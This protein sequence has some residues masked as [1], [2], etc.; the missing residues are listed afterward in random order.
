MK[1]ASTEKPVISIIIPTK[2]EERNI[3]LC[4]DSIKK[5]TFPQNEIEIIVVDNHSTDATKKIAREYTQNIFTKGPE[6]SAQRN[7]GAKKCHGK[8]YMYLDADMTLSPTVIQEVV[9]I[10]E[11]NK[12]IIGLYIPELVTGELYWSQVRRF[13]RSFYYGTV[14]D[15]IRIVRTA[16]LKKVGGF[17]ETLTGPEDW[18]FDKKIRQ[19]GQVRIITSPMYHNETEFNIGKYL[20]KKYY[21]SK[22]FDTYISKWGKDDP[23]IKKQFSL[24][25][26]F[27]VVFIE[28]GHWKE[29]FRHPL[30]TAGMI[31]LRILVGIQFLRS[32]KYSLLTS[33]KLSSMPYE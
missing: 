19:R 27:G 10:F 15:C 3:R 30:L 9:E 25:Y 16:D 26:R 12:N 28:N 20:K 6:R 21:Y 11:K 31:F 33:T 2:N 24:L 8:Y 32:K 17:D 14:I 1:N 13:E 18:D 7:L 23:D 29:L 5:Q 4:L 22:T